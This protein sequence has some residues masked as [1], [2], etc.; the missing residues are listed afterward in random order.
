L[1]GVAR[2]SWTR[3]ECRSRAR[4]R[5]KCIGWCNWKMGD[6]PMRRHIENMKNFFHFS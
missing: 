5:Y 6:F 4:A 3:T 1:L 2:A